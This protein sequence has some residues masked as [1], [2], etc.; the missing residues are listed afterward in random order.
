MISGSEKLTLSVA[1]AVVKVP[2][3]D[4]IETDGEDFTS[5]SDASPDAG[6]KL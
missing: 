1:Y 4:S 3:D 5:D 2:V 6:E